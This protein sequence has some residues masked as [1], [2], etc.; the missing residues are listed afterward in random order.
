M[1]VPIAVLS[2]AV[3]FMFSCDETAEGCLDLLAENY[4]FEAVNECDSCCTYPTASISLS[5]IQ[6]TL[7][8][9][10]N[11][12]LLLANGDSVLIQDWVLLMSEFVFSS[13]K[14]DYTIRDSI[15][16]NMISTKDDFIVFLDRGSRQIGNTAFQDT[17]NSI[18]VRTGFNTQMIELFKPFDNLDQDSQLDLALDSMYNSISD[19]YYSMRFVLE[20]P[21]QERSVNVSVSNSDVLVFDDLDFFVK[22]GTD[23]SLKMN[24]DMDVLFS[25]ISSDLAEED[26]MQI[27][28][29]NIQ[30]S[31]NIE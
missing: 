31:I 21:E 12:T 1:R 16:S 22:G 15:S 13:N 30:S 10:L 7:S 24:M 27:I 14:M 3:F 23:W 8:F 29:G 5:F 6:D 19:D 26:I 11:D 9:N 20:F 17:L 2:I 18:Q 25:G 4:S 28:S